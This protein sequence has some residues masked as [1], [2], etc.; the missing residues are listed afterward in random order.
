MKRMLLAILGLLF[1]AC[2]SGSQSADSELPFHLSVRVEQRNEARPVA[3][4]EVRNDGRHS[5]AFTP[6]F[7]FRDLYLFLEIRDALGQPVPYPLE[8]QYELLVQPPYRCLR[9]SRSLRMQ[10]ELFEWFHVIGGRVEPETVAGVGPYAFDLAPGTYRIRAV[11]DARR[12]SRRGVCRTL[13][14]VA[15]S[16]WRSFE[17]MGSVEA[18]GARQ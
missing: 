1:L 6:T 16:E 17:V 5:V 11:Y 9:P 8:S 3:I 7:G 18:R 10:I 12:P 4:V 14:G 15:R 2:A 13:P